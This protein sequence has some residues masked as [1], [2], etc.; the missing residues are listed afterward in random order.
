LQASLN[1]RRS[2]LEALD[3]DAGLAGVAVDRM[4]AVLRR[5]DTSESKGRRWDILLQFGFMAPQAIVA[6]IIGF[7]LGL[8]GNSL[9]SLPK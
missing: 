3:R 8:L 5:L 7:F 4:N 9:F 6:G 2:E 1:A